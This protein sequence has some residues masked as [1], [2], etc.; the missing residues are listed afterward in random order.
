MLA[1]LYVEDKLPASEKKK[2]IKKGKTKMMV[3]NWMTGLT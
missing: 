1:I 2:R 3:E